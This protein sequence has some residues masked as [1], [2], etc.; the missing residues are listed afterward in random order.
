MKNYLSGN[1]LYPS[2]CTFLNLFRP[3]PPQPSVRTIFRF[4]NTLPCVPSSAL[5]CLSTCCEVRNV[6]FQM[7]H[8]FSFD[9]LCLFLP[10]VSF[11]ALLFLHLSIQIPFYVIV[12]EKGTISQRGGRVLLNAGSVINAA[13]ER[14]LASLSDELYSD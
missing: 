6:G 10:L 9:P 7:S 1:R 4:T 2:H 3:P 13:V 8:I 12:K 11:P 14:N 5:R